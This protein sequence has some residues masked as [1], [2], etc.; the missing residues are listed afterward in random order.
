MASPGRAA[1]ERGRA[2]APGRGTRGARGFFRVR[3]GLPPH[4]AHLALPP[5]RACARHWREIHPLSCRLTTSE[6]P[7][8]PPLPLASCL[9]GTRNAM[10]RAVRN[11]SEPAARRD[12]QSKT[13][14]LIHRIEAFRGDKTRN[15]LKAAAIARELRDPRSVT[16]SR[17][18][19]PT[20]SNDESP[21]MH[22]GFVCLL[23]PILP[24]TEPS[25]RSARYARCRFFK[26]RKW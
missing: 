22:R 15:T 6:S 23:T 1:S 13:I 4:G 17:Y 16:T 25:R 21:T 9:D 2:A 5:I 3:P 20:I 14:L 19:T 24:A 8:V 10:V 11:T 18:R 12:V 7:K 26:F